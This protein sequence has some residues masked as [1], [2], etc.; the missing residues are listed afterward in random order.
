LELYLNKIYLGNRAYGFGAASEIYYG[1]PLNQLNLA[2]MAMLATIPKAP[3]KYNPIADPERALIRRTY[4]LGR[5]LELGYIDTAAYDEAMAAP[6]TASYHGVVSEVDAYYVG[7][8]VRADLVARVGEEAAYSDGYRVVTTLDS[9]LQKTANRSIRDALQEY[10]LRY[11]YRGPIGHLEAESFDVDTLAEDFDAV[12]GEIPEPGNLQAAVVLEL[13]ETV[14][15]V[16]VRGVGPI[17]IGMAGLEWAAPALDLRQTGPTPEVPA[18]VLAVGD[19]IYVLRDP[20]IAAEI[21]PEADEGGINADDNIEAGWRLAQIPEVQGALVSLDPEDGAVVSLV[22]GYDFFYSKYNRAVQARRQPGSSFKPFIYSAA[23][24]NGFTPATI[25]NDAPV[26]FADEEL[27]DVWRPQNDSGRFY[28]PTR[29]REALVNSR[30][31]VSIRV[32]QTMGIGNAIGYLSNTYGF[33]RDRLPRNLSLAL[34]S[35]AYSPM[36][37]ATAYTVIAN[38]GYRVQPYYIDEIIGPGGKT[39]FSADPA[40]VCPDCEAVEAEL[41]AANVA[42]DGDVNDEREPLPQDPK[43][44]STREE[45]A[46]PVAVPLPLNDAAF[47]GVIERRE[48]RIAERVQS[49]PVNYLIADMMRDVIQRGTGRRARVLGREDISGKTGTTNEYR[50]A[51]FSGFNPEIVTTVWIGFD[52]FSTLGRGEYGGRAALPAW[53][54]YMRVAL[55]GTPETYHDRPPGLVTVRID[56]ETGLLAGTGNPDAIFETF[57]EG[58]LPPEQPAIVHENGEDG[59]DDDTEQSLF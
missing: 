42:G 25:V 17:E 49:A 5:M 52:D 35:G 23:L 33:D 32:L 29:F 38:G 26:V 12:A 44:E 24:A 45:S 31:L 18:D 56:P 54:D 34:G 59:E 14:A 7:E 57:I 37:M 41:A 4:V 51:W 50:D 6:V 16:F 10:D 48:P 30:N 58:T 20:E 55:A 28:G 46:E 22:G 19:I 40:I 1:K 15:R 27:E 43:P 3:S 2:Q 39:I 21:E 8:L 13:N 53:I 11:G 36:E 47:A 9:R